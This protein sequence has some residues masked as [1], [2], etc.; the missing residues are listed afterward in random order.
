MSAVHLPLPVFVSN[1][2]CLSPT[3]A[4]AAAV[5]AALPSPPCARACVCA[6][7]RVPV[8]ASEGAGPVVVH[9]GRVS[10]SVLSSAR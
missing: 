5:A 9:S 7:V 8:S 4:A 3:F 6:S 10:G 1:Y 2:P